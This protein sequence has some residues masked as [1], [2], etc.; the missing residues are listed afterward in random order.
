VPV[1]ET[2]SATALL[3]ETSPTLSWN[4][5]LLNSGTPPSSSPSFVA[6]A[7]TENIPAAPP[8]TATAAATTPPFRSLVSVSVSKS[9]STVAKDGLSDESDE[10]SSMLSRSS[11]LLNSGARSPSSPTLVVVIT[12]TD[13]APTVPPAT[14]ARATTPS[15]V[16]VSAYKTLSETAKDVWSDETSSLITWSSLSSTLR[17]L[18][19]SSPGFLVASTAP[20]N[21]PTD[22]P[23]TAAAAT[24]PPPELDS[25]S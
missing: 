22:P 7:A 23:A 10:T 5:F 14:A 21:A 8:A 2:L 20:D 12:A 18:A 6:N 9:F 24:P 3:D 16:S 19:P 17:T 25:V 15:S 13:N 1:S 4:L 11:V